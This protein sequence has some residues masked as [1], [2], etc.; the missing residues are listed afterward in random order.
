MGEQ[1]LEMGSWEGIRYREEF[2][3]YLHATI[4]YREKRKTI[5]SK[6]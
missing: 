2:N 3:W 6:V 4:N 1:V 5:L